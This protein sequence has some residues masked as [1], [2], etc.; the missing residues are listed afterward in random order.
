VLNS[1]VDL[2]LFL[3][4]TRIFAF[5]PLAA[6]VLSFAAGTFNSFFLNKIFTFNNSADGIMITRQ[7][8]RFILVSICVLL[9]HQSSI[10]VFH[11]DM[12]ASDFI[13]KLFGIGV[14]VFVGFSLN[15]FWVFH[16]QS[17]NR[18]R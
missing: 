12:G 1:G 7:C 10:I 13:A 18:I 9:V 3:A 14:G 11:H 4:F 6:S 16:Q 5:A 8:F 17:G 2:V 15:K